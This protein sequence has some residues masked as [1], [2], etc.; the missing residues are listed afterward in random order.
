MELGQR[1]ALV[2]VK[3]PREA[4][5]VPSLVVHEVHVFFSDLD[6]DDM[7]ELHRDV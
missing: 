3:G 1:C 2:E 5:L 6:P 7:S 4:L